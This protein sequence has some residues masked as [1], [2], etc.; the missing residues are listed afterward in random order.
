MKQ[1]GREQTNVSL[2]FRHSLGAQTPEVGIQQASPT[3]KCHSTDPCQDQDFVSASQR[4]WSEK[5][6]ERQTQ[7]WA[8]GAG[9]APCT[10]S[11]SEAE[12]EMQG[13]L[14]RG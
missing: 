12:T 6:G 10:G 14:R 3:V 11:W 4:G 1:A 7:P 2:G 13:S 5:G 9:L 8:C